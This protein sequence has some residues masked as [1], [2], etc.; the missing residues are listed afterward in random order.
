[1]LTS[2]LFSRVF[3]NPPKSRLEQWHPWRVPNG[4]CGPGVTPTDYV[5]HWCVIGHCVGVMAAHWVSQTMVF[6]TFHPPYLTA[7]PTHPLY[8][9]Y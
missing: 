3:A 9:Q 7:L 5:D 6:A 4:Y 2:L 1:M 8:Y